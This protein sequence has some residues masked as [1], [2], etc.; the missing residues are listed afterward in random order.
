[1]GTAA[2]KIVWLRHDLRLKD[3]PA[4][5]HA[6]YNKTPIIPVFIY[7][8]QA[9]DRDY[10]AAQKW[11][12]H[13]ALT[14]LRNDLK[15]HEVDLIIREGDSLKILQDLIKQT[16]AVGI[17]WNRLYEKWSI[18]RDSHIKE[19]LKSDGIEVE[20]YNG[21]LLFEPWEIKKGSGDPYRVFTPF[22]KECIRNID[23]IESPLP[24][25]NSLVDGDLPIGDIR[26]L[27]FL[28]KTRWDKSM[29][30]HWEISEN[31]AWDRLN[32][33][34]D[35]GL[36]H[37][38]DGRDLPAKDWT[39]KL[40]PYLR[41]GMI[42]PRSIW[43]EANAYSIA[44]NVQD[45]NRDNFLSEIGW[46]EFCHG[47]LYYNPTMK[48]EPLQ[49]K[50]KNFPWQP[51]KDF[52][53]AWQRGLTG[54]PIVDAGMRQLWQT[55]WMHNRVRMIVGSLM[56]KHMLQ[57]WQDG[58]T[59]FWDTLVDACPA[60]NTAGWQWIGGC[61]A[62]AAPYFRIFNPMTQAKKFD[63]DGDY[64]RTFVPELKNLPDKYIHEPWEAPQDVLNKAGV[65][66]GKDYPRL[67][68]DHDH[69]RKRALEAFESL[70]N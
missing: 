47:L 65:I 50:F 66:L 39:S 56:V 1:M 27:N 41:W 43:H 51:N 62:D 4:L 3:N 57:P 48:S 17:T 31:G 8:P 24:V 59:W 61:G 30:E 60:N 54:Y 55:G 26:D 45:K 35:N 6:A 42:S 5:Y 23:R 68:I 18:D 16:G 38:K 11:W 52:Q 14:S 10:G 70:K 69:G 2:P 20:S 15:S 44:H 19:T 12:L 32:H 34:L 64:I 53:T 49:D 22:W 7:D 46:R 29:T 40:S 67:I 9:M 63:P 58:E 25:P 13:H 36:N 21:S 37:Y 33:F 28:P